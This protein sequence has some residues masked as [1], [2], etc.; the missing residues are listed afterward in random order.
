MPTVNDKFRAL[1]SLNQDEY[2]SLLNV[3]DELV[4]EKM[5]IC[6]LKGQY[7]I[8]KLYDDHGSCSLVGSKA[9][10]DFILMYLKENPNQAYHGQLFNISQSKVCQWIR[11]LLPVLEASLVKMG[12]MPQIG[13]EFIEQED[14]SHYLL[15]D[16]TERQVPRDTDYENQ[17][18][19]YSGKKKLH[20]LKNLVITDQNAK[21]LFVSESEYGSVHDK[22]LWDQVLFKF[23]DKNVLADLG[24]I[25]IDKDF[26]NV[27]LPYKKRK[28]STLTDLQKKINKEIGSARV[29]IEHA[30]AGIKRLKIIRN[31]IRLKTYEIRD[32]VFRIA[33]ALHNL[34]V[35]FRTLQNFS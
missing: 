25:G 7:R 9:K 21:L 13:T 28:N 27:I 29:K 26:D 19:A 18:E 16:V 12:M 8:F 34:R 35:E 2:E 24:F 4:K 5:A 33:A 17:E 15:V 32:Q 20:T 31:K 22:T 23:K 11:Y 30:F 6:T 3:F 10:L 14:D 1:V